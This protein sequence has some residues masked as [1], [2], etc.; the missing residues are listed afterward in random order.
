MKM[1]FQTLALAAIL[2]NLTACV[3]EVPVGPP[4]A[5]VAAVPA[6]VPYPY[7]YYGCCYAYPEYPPYGYGYY[8]PAVGVGVYEGGY[9]HGWYHWR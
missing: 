8:G 6:P 1:F 9:G 7:P 5:P 3:A 2:V 4:P